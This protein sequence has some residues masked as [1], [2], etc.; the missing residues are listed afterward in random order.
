VPKPPEI[1]SSLAYGRFTYLVTRPAW[2]PDSRRFVAGDLA[3]NLCVFEQR[4]GRYVASVIRP[5][6]PSKAYAGPQVFGVAW[7]APN[8]I[9]SVERANTYQRRSGDLSESAVAPYVGRDSI[10]SGG[11]GA[12]VVVPGESSANVLD[13]P[14]LAKRMYTSIGHHDFSGPR[15]TAFA[16]APRCTLFAACSDGGSEETA[17]GM[18]T[19]RGRPRIDIVD[20]ATRKTIASIPELARAL[21]F[22]PWRK[23]LLVAAYGSKDVQCF[24][25][26]GT[27]VRS[28]EAHASG[29]RSMAVTERWIITGSDS[30][31]TLA[32]WDPDSL[33]QVASVAL[34]KRMSTDW[35]V[36]SPDGLRFLTQAV[37]HDKHFPLQV[38][39]IDLQPVCSICE[40]I[41]TSI[42]ANTG[43]DVY[44]PATVQPLKHLDLERDQDLWRCP[45]CDAIYEFTS[46]QSWTGSGNN[47]NDTLDRLAPDHAATV[48]ALLDGGKA[49]LDDDQLHALFALPP[50]PQKLVFWVLFRRSRAMLRSAV[51][52]MVKRL[53]SMGFDPGFDGPQYFLKSIGQLSAE[54][55]H[56]VREAIGTTKYKPPHPFDNLLQEL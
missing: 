55:A 10:E 11:D 45:E 34:E 16:G 36:P 9:V 25:Y 40:H 15:I 24:D 2:S 29:V 53:A 32:L 48:R 50:L 49:P 41:P 21:A 39:R 31:G 23:Q 19:D 12:W 28:F 42:V 52:R 18:P 22:D 33:Q 20:V 14:G 17:M 37:P 43:R 47:D 30:D 3:G 56:R 5:D 27:L 51:P 6:P 35:I 26:D 8:H 54:D 1:L 7:P 38:W 13:V 4:D 44:L 46:E